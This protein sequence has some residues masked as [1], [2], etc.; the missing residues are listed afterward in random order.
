MTGALAAVAYWWCLPFVVLMVVFTGAG[1]EILLDR[2][3]DLL[4]IPVADLLCYYVATILCL[5][6]LG[7]FVLHSLRRAAVT[8]PERIWLPTFFLPTYIAGLESLRLFV[9]SM[10]CTPGASSMNPAEEVA[11]GMVINAEAFLLT[12]VSGGLAAR[13]CGHRSAL[14]LP[15]PAVVVPIVAGVALPWC[16][17]LYLIH[18]LPW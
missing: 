10:R 2:I 12:I 13:L 8:A 14:G 4:P 9:W 6:V 11:W 16:A 1:T 15:I 7:V 5:C 3:Y 18:G 17:A